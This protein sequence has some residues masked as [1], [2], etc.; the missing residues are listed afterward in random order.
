M[1]RAHER[2][3]ICVLGGLTLCFATAN[4]LAA[5]SP[6]KAP[7]TAVLPAP[8]GPANPSGK[9]AAVRFEPPLDSSIP[10]NEFGKLVRLGR[11]IFT[12]TKKHAGQY[13]GNDLRCSNCHLDA[14]RLRD[15][16][17]LWSA[18]VAYPQYRAKTKEVDTFA[19]RLRGCFQYSMNGK[20][21]PLGSEPLVAL[22]VYSYWMATGAPVNTKLQGGGYPRLSPAA[23]QPD[24]ARGQAVYTERCTL[25][26]GANGE[27][28]KAGTA[29]VFPPLWGARSFNWGAGM[30]QINNAAGFIKANMPLG[31]GGTLTDQQAWDVAFFM[32]AHERPQDPRYTGSVAETRKKFHDAP[33][34]LY[35]IVVNGHLLGSGALPVQKMSRIEGAR[36]K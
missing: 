5:D 12:D 1:T 14:G 26:H 31:L 9:P 4:T 30:H 10:D 35:G 7:S 29:Q 27:G 22:E 16:A 18:Y 33:D 13:V 36:S 17:P 11:A 20:A 32:N 8:V 19:E 21:P 3:S 24:Y 34:S 28:Q 6:P 2:I 23:Q 15:S 25:C